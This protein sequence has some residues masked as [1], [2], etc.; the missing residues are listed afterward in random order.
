MKM[1]QLDATLYLSAKEFTPEILSATVVTLAFIPSI[2]FK[3]DT[4]SE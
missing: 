4:K 2:A 1:D 3:S